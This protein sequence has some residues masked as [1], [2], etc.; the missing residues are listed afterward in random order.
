M[1]LAL[2]EARPY[3]EPTTL[4][5]VGGTVLICTSLGPFDEF[6]EGRYA[7]TLILESS[8][9]GTKRA[10]KNVYRMRKVCVLDNLY[11][12]ATLVFVS[13]SSW[14]MSGEAPPSCLSIRMRQ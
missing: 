14:R 1:P 10:L 13:A 12:T 6:S 9:A 11:S 3:Q 7:V 4:D 2:T 8:M 5:T